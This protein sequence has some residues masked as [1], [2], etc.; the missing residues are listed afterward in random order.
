MEQDRARWD[1]R[2]A[3]AGPTVPRPPDALVDA[4]LVDEVPASGRLLDVACGTGPVARWALAR[5]L[6]VV[7]L[8]ASG[9]A[10][11]ELRNASEAADPGGETRLDARRVDLDD[12]LPAELGSFDVVVVQRFRDTGVLAAAPGLVRPGGLLIITVLS[13]VGADAPG[14][15]RAAPGELEAVV[16]A[17][18]PTWTR[19]VHVEGG[20]EASLV[21]RRR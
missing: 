17:D 7:A 19:L 5:G 4:G 10:I 20:G 1:E 11:D 9:H 13:E 6:D 2:H 15:F 3:A 12:G 8:D 21:V 18:D 14:P 16:A